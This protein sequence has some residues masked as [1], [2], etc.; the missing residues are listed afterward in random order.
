MASATPDIFGDFARIIDQVLDA[1]GDPKLIVQALRNLAEGKPAF[2]N[3]GARMEPLSG[4][5]STPQADTTNRYQETM[6]KLLQWGIR[7]FPLNPVDSVGVRSLWF[8]MS[9]S[10]TAGAD[11][12]NGA[13]NCRSCAGVEMP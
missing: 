10:S 3:T 12:I 9:V 1:V 4:L 7:N 6:R 11:I 13:F 2:L 5:G 8:T